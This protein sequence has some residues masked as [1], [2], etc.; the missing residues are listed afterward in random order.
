MATGLQPPLEPAVAMEQHAA[1]THHY[2]RG[3][4]M[5]ERRMP[6]E[7]VGQHDQLI[8]DDHPGLLL[9]IIPGLMITYVHDET[10]D[11]RVCVSGLAGLRHGHIIAGSAALCRVDDAEWTMPSGRTTP[12][13]LVGGSGGLAT[14]A[15]DPA[16]LAL[17]GSTPDALTLTTGQCMLQARLSH[18]AQITDG[19]CLVG[20]LIGDRV[21]HI[22]I[23]APAG[24]V[25]APGGTHEN[26]PCY[27]RDH[28]SFHHSGKSATWEYVAP[29]QK[30]VEPTVWPTEGARVHRERW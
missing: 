29:R 16:T 2:R 4:D 9:A 5:G 23:D 12:A 1:S 13:Y 27:G 19:L 8:E 22:W 30:M 14:L 28:W 25:L 7:R 17:G 10:C 24:C 6:I 26:I 21:E 3:R 11:F 18:G 20:L 15:V